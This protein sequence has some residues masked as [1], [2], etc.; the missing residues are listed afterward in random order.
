MVSIGDGTVRWVMRRRFAGALLALLAPAAPAQSPAE[1]RY[2]ISTVMGSGQLPFSGHGGPAASAVLVAPEALAADGNGNLY[3]TDLYYH[4][5]FRIDAAGAIRVFAGSGARGYS[6]DGGPAAD[7][8]LNLPGAL[9]P[10]PDG[11]LL[12]GDSGNGAI[13]V[14]AANG[15]ISTIAGGG[16]A[17]A[18]DSVLATEA[19]LGAV[20]GIIVEGSGRIVFS[21][22]DDSRVWRIEADGRLRAVAGTG[23]P[24]YLGDGGQARAAQLSGPKGLAL[25]RDGNLFIA[26]QFNHRIRRVGADGVIS[27]HAGIGQIGDSGDG[28]PARAARIGLPQDIV[29]DGAGNLIFTDYAYGKVRQ[30]NPAGG[31]LTI[32][33]GIHSRALAGPSGITIDASGR[34]L[35]AASQGRA[36]VRVVPSQS[37][38][39]IAGSPAIAVGDGGPALN[40]TL[41]DPT[42][43]AVDAQGAVYVA[44]YADHRIRR[45]LA[46]GTV[47]TIAGT[48]AAGY[49]G[50]GAPATQAVVGNPHALRIG[51]AGD[52]LISFFYGGGI[53]RIHNGVIDRVAGGSS[54]GYV[55][56]GGNALV[57]LFNG[58]SGFATDADGNIYLADRFNHRLRRI[59][60]TGVVTTLVGTGVEG[61]SGD[62]GPAAAARLSQP[63]GVAISPM[64]GEIYIADEGNRVIR[65]IDRNLVVSTFF[66]DPAASGVTGDPGRAVFT[67][68]DFD[69][70]GNLFVA[71]STLNRIWRITPERVATVIAGTGEEGFSGDG[72]DARNARV[73]QPRALAV[74]ASGDVY[75]VDAGNA[76]VRRLT[77]AA[78]LPPNVM[79]AASFLG[80]AVAPGQI[81]TIFTEADSGPVQLTAA[82]LDAS[83]R[84]STTLAATRVYFDDLP[85]PLVYTSRRQISAIV[86]YGVAGRSQARVRVEYQGATTV[87]GIAAIAATAPGVFTYSGGAGQAVAVNEDGTFND[88]ANRAAAGSIAVVYVTGEGVTTPAGV[89]GRIAGEV[90]PAPVA[91]VEVF[92]GGVRADVIYAGAAPGVVTGVMQVNFRIPAQAAASPS[93]PLS[94]RVAGAASQNG[95]T[96]AVR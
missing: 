32:A 37:A 22:L 52:L 29:F 55:G 42:G 78:N 41:I 51:P 82:A 76:R 75:F 25:D 87:S 34:L 13:R 56:D 84:V 5:V 69:S 18:A 36:V 73:S 50:D 79:H 16:R 59:S 46:D 12:I 57:A 27:T 7:A 11:R 15:R 35:V 49:A 86:P 95:V 92:V 19:A 66:G 90:L 45:T 80:G 96:I 23:Q 28:G 89:D 3:L 94:V 2:I 31:I 48:G 14:V 40:A 91:T 93:V 60:T 85:A 68:L 26:D 65:R 17:T 70:P 74:T 54:L 39:V 38:T 6:G 67:G 47:R 71:S 43:L 1:S 4:R 63:S 72:G 33:S 9:I 77:A 24:G 62:G 8:R 83:G 88:A 30:I 20:G 64:T 10:H 58:S 44:D 21:T 53:R 61:Y 81:V